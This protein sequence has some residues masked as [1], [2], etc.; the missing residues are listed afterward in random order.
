MQIAGD[1]HYEK[2]GQLHTE[3]LTC[4]Q[5]YGALEMQLQKHLFQSAQLL[6][7]L[8]FFTSQNPCLQKN[9]NPTLIS[10][11]SITFQVRNST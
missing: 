11:G 4:S 10:D 2:K 7:N 8:P 1:I 6:H 9:Q 5:F 3:I